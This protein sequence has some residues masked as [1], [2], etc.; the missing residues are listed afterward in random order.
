MGGQACIFY[1][2]A[3]FSRDTDIVLPATSQNLKRLSLA[4][5]DLLAECIAVPPFSGAYLKKGH[6]VHFR[7]HHSDAQGSRLDVMSLLR[8]VS[9][10]G[11]LWKR[12]T[13]ITL[14]TGEIIELM[15]LQ[16]LVQAKKTQ[17]DK[18]WAMIR[19]LVETHLAQNKNSPSSAQIDF[20]LKELRDSSLLTDIAGKYPDRP[21]KLAHRRPLL[22]FARDR[23][24]ESLVMALL[25]EENMEREKDR[26]YWK[27][28]RAE[29]EKLRRNAGGFRK[30]D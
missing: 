6:A 4:L 17:R 29:M 10:F 7:C 2:A 9:P 8:G 1:G 30:R 12:R 25:K 13:T 19:R 21:A 27:P 23:N 5:S 11:V 3:E 26:E 24:D 16:D 28:L 15:S 14:E 20:W 18:D 22:S